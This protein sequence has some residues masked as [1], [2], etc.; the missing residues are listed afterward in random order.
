MFVKVNLHV[1]LQHTLVKQVHEPFVNVMN[2]LRM[3]INHSQM[4][5]SEVQSN[6]HTLEELA[7]FIIAQVPHMSYN[8]IVRLRDGMIL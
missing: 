6:Y 5:V 3:F 2:H 8:Y 7:V 4:L 1:T